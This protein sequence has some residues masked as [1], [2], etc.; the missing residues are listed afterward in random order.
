MRL[1][2]LLREPLMRTFRVVVIDVGGHD[3]LEMGLV[4]DKQSIQALLPHGTLLAPPVNVRY[5]LGSCT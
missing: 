2:R 4:D 3:T 5:D 1:E